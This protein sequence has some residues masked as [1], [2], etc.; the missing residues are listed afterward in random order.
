VPRQSSRPSLR[1]YPVKLL[2]SKL[3]KTLCFMEKSTATMQAFGMSKGTHAHGVGA[4]THSE[5]GLHNGASRD[6]PL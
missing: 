6:S 3:N 2:A 5:H 1:S 4:S